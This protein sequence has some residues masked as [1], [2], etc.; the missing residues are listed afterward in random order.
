MK[1]KLNLL[2]L[3]VLCLGSSSLHA[4]ERIPVNSADELPRISYEVPVVPSQLLLQPE[5][6]DTL[7]GQVERDLESIL[8][9]YEIKD[10][11][12]LGVFWW[13]SVM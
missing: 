7:L 9:R 1:N 10:Q 12:T 4:Q 3:I 2:S 11:A 6:F 8:S 5:A 13:I